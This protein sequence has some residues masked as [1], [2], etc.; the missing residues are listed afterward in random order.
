M[1]S[2]QKRLK[3][4]EFSLAQAVKY[5]SESSWGRSFPHYLVFAQLKP[6]QFVQNHVKDFMDVVG[7]F[8]LQ[9]EKDG[10]DSK[11]LQ[12]YEQATELLPQNTK[13]LTNYASILFKQGKTEESEKLL[14]RVLSIDKDY[15]LARDRLENLAS[16]LLERWHFPMLNDAVRNEKYKTAINNKIKN[17]CDTVLDIG[18]GTGLLSLYASE[19]GASAV[20]ACDAS[21][22]MAMTA[23]DVFSLNA[24]GSKIRLIPKLSMDL[25]TDDVPEPIK[26]LVTETF[27][28]GLLGEHILI[29]LNHAWNNQLQSPSSSNPFAVCS[30]I[31]PGSAQF[32]VAPISCPHVA[33]KHL[34]HRDKYG[35]LKLDKLNIKSNFTTKDDREPYCCEDLKSV[36]ESFKL[37]AQPKRLFSIDFQNKHEVEDM[38]RVGQ[39]KSLQFNVNRDGECHA[40]A[41]WFTLTLDD[42]V[43]LSTSPEEGSC[44]HQAIFPVLSDKTKVYKDSSIIEVEFKIH[45]HVEMIN[46][47][48]RFIQPPTVNGNGVEKRC[49]G[50][51]IYL[52]SSYINMINCT[53]M[54]QIYQWTAYYASRDVCCENIL[55]L[56]SELP[57][58]SLQLAKTSPT[59]NFTLK[60]DTGDKEAV[61]CL[62][63]F[64]T[65]AATHNEFDVKKF[66]CITELPDNTSEKFNVCLVKPVLSSGRLNDQLMLGLDHIVTTLVPHSGLLLP[67][68]LQLWAQIIESEELCK[69]SHLRSNEPVSGFKIADQINILAV[70]HQQDL[71]YHTLNKKELSEAI[72]VRDIDLTSPD[73]SRQFSHTT[74]NITQSGQ[75]SAVIYWFVQDF[76]WNLHLSTLQS[77]SFSQCAVMCKEESVQQGQHVQ[78]ATQMEN[79]LVYF[80]IK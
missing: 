17:G 23:R 26:L 75:I 15:L 46:F 47:E 62:L 48:A 24:A 11:V 51:K 80:C 79:G 59:S 32:F 1:S 50:D 49:S 19:G 70:T 58:L 30:S 54:E 41:A 67:H 20:Y 77:T 55:D 31:I 61:R 34:F 73:L 76:G 22:V 13:L 6:E 16:S 42:D 38:L 72:H 56:T 45:K 69:L 74:V 10:K 65:A 2:E 52:P 7:A 14:L 78:L 35:Y 43:S 8:S 63:D 27:D 18:T 57:L 4:A 12:V 60:V 33:R 36:P 9:L 37:L 5:K 40:M 25:T 3:I 71:N 39:N 29:S 53:T 21:E 28:A 66:S 44:W 68:K 64:I